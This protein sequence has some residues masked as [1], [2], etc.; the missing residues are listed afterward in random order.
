MKAHEVSVKSQQLISLTEVKCSVVDL[1]LRS[2]LYQSL[3]S[4]C[5]L[6]V[7][8]GAPPRQEIQK[9]TETILVHHYDPFNSLNSAYK[10]ELS[11]GTD[12]VLY[13]AG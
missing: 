12:V 3:P 10:G 2:Y 6:A 7:H 13:P 1:R 4:R 8:R 9:Q 5:A 11:R